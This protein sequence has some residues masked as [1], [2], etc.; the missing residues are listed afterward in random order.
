MPAWAVVALA[1]DNVAAW[2]SGSER[3]NVIAVASQVY[4][5]CNIG[6]IDAEIISYR[7]TELRRCVSRQHS[8]VID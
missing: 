2:R 6:N 3:E 8:L 4:G 1:R 7:C 5:G